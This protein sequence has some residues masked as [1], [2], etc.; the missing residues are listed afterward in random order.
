M[1]GHSLQHNPNN[2]SSQYVTQSGK[3]ELRIFNTARI[4][5]AQNL[6]QDLDYESLQYATQSGL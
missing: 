3:L 2:E 4:M 1:R 6:Q 5:G